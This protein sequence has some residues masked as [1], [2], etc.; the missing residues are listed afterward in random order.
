MATT[1]SEYN[2]N[3][4]FGIEFKE[5]RLKKAIKLIRKLKPGNMLDVGC[6]TGDWMAFWSDNNWNVAGI[7]VSTDSVAATKEKG[8]EAKQ[9][10]LARQPIPYKSN[11]FDLIFAGEIIEHLVD[12]DH[13][14]SELNRCLKP[15]G[16]LLLTTPN[17]ASFE[18]RIRLLLGIYPRWL[19]YSLREC[20]HVRGYTPGI[21]KRQLAEH[22]FKI[23][24]HLGNWVPFLPQSVT[25]DI[26]APWLAF[27]GSL[28]PSLAMD[29]IMLARKQT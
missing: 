25:D 21:L 17:L 12:T 14:L 16:H 3:R 18:N 4:A 26:K 19:D 24:Q 9:C 29:I 1:V 11:T 22:H 6:S 27:T 7:D 2:A 13:F 5:S 20:G 28:C 23:Q 15:G 10:D 8:F